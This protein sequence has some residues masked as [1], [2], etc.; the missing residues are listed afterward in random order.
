MAALMPMP[1]T[2]NGIAATAIAT[3]IVAQWATRRPVEEI[4]RAGA[5]RRGRD[6]DQPGRP[7]YPTWPPALARR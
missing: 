5:E 6:D 1:S 2:R 3:K 4:A 7:R